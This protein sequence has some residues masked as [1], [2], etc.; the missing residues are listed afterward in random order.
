[1]AF[2]FRLGSAVKFDVLA[3]KRYERLKEVAYRQV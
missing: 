2:G 3:P 1:M